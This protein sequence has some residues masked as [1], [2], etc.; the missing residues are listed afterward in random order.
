M[1]VRERKEG[2]GEGGEGAGRTQQGGWVHIKRG[3]SWGEGVQQSK[4]G[5]SGRN[6]CGCAMLAQAFLFIGLILRCFVPFTSVFGGSVCLRHAQR[7]ASIGRQQSTAPPSSL[8]PTPSFSEPHLLT[9]HVLC[10]AR[11]PCAA[12]LQVCPRHRSPASREARRSSQQSRSALDLT[13]AAVAAAAVSLGG[14]SVMGRTVVWG[15]CGSVA[16]MS[17]CVCLCECVFRYAPANNL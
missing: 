5:S 15:V 13:A 2:R 11:A 12:A 16:C 6:V 1:G 3:Q 8:P 17:V 10:R 9:A 4:C 7:Q 14:A